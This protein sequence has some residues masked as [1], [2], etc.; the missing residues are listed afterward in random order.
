M[1]EL[2]RRAGGRPRLRA[3]LAIAGGDRRQGRRER[4]DDAASARRPAAPTSP[5]I[6]RPADRRARPA[7]TLRRRPRRRRVGRLRTCRRWRA[8]PRP[9]WRRRASG[10]GPRNGATTRQVDERSRRVDRRAS[11]SASPASSEAR[12]SPRAVGMDDEEPVEAGPRQDALDRRLRRAQLDLASGARRLGVVAAC[13]ADQPASGSG[14]GLAVHDPDDRVQG[15]EP[16][17]GHEPQVAQVEEELPR[18]AVVQLG[19]RRRS[20]ASKLDASSSPSRATTVTG[21]GPRLLDRGLQGH[22]R[23]SFGRGSQSAGQGQYIAAAGPRSIGQSSP[24]PG[25][26]GGCPS[27]RAGDARAGRVRSGSGHERRVER[28]ARRPRA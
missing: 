7:S 17:A 8:R 16:G 26:S 5:D 20:G 18:P 23:S 3:V 13:R 27:R 2:R 14:G 12:R 9:R 4:L 24:S 21:H 22:Q 15:D 11:Q 10:R 1:G 25:A 28:R 6:A 19:G